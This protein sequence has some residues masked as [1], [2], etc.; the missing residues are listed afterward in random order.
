MKGREMEFRPLRRIKQ[1]LA[2][3]EIIKLLEAEK[4]AVLAVNGDDGYPYAVPIDY[5]YDNESNKLYFHGAGTGHKYDSIS[6][7]DKV[8]LTIYGNE[9]H[10]E[11]DWAPYLQSV[12]IFGRCRV[13]SADEKLPY[14]KKLGIKYYPT[15]A[16]VDKI[17]EETENRMQVFEIS[18]EHICG[19]QIHEC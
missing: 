9:E 4:R 10:R 13:M 12:V 1:E 17:I 7:D 2:N 18:I 15:E 6:R 8:C 19:K 5:Y 3:E 16:A 11:G 14:A